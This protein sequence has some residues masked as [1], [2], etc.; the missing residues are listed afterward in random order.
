MSGDT[1]N[2]QQLL[3]DTLES[4]DILGG[5]YS[6]LK[7]IN[8]NSH[9]DRR[10]CLSLVFK[11][12]DTLTGSCV[13]IKFMDPSWLSDKY[14]LAGFDREPEILATLEGKR[15]LTLIEAKKEF[16]WQLLGSS[17]GGEGLAPTAIPMGY[18]VTEWLSDDIDEYFFRHKSFNPTER[19]MIFKLIVLAISSLH[20]KNVFH[21]DLKRD[22]LRSYT[23]QG[24]KTVVAIDFGTAARQDSDLYM[25]VYDRQVGAQGYAAPE[26]IHLGLAGC[27]EV[28]HLNDIYALGCILFELFNEKQ[29]FGHLL[30]YSSNYEKIALILSHAVVG[31]SALDKKLNILRL[32]IPQYKHALTTPSILSAGHSVPSA[33]SNIIEKLHADLCCFHFDERLSDFN[34][35]IRSIDT[36][37]GV[38]TNEKAVQRA[39]KLKRSMRSR[40]LEK[41]KRREEKLGGYLHDRGRIPC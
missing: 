17:S 3:I 15:C 28:A 5:R 36:A 32:A 16:P 10:G 22:N 2:S 41:V 14:R 9:E 38:L 30:D 26:A 18:F 35:I 19:L 23:D 21:R 4:L 27:R 20:R 8:F 12:L 25:N 29:F 13:A 33:V 6:D 31:E 24:E 37:F 39:L 34:K 11:A 1:D 40:R 7:C